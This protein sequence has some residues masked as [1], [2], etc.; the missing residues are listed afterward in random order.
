[1]P[2]ILKKFSMTA[3]GTEA[4][5]KSY[6]YNDANQLLKEIKTASGTTSTTTYTYDNNGNQLAKSTGSTATSVTNTYNAFNQLTASSVGGTST[7]YTYTPDGLRLTKGNLT[8]LYDRGN[9]VLEMQNSSVKSSYVYGIGLVSGAISGYSGQ[10]YFIHNGHGDI[11]QLQNSSRTVV[12]EYTYDAFGN[13]ENPVSADANPFRYAGEYYDT[14]TG[15]Y[16]LR[17]RYYDPVVGRFTQEDTVRAIS[18][19]LP[20]GQSVL[21]P[22][23]QNLYVYCA[24][25]PV[26]Y[27]DGSGHAWETLF[28]W[29]SFLDSAKKAYEEPSAENFLFAAWDAG[30]VLLPLVPASYSVKVVGKIDDIV[31]A[32]KTVDKVTDSVKAAGKVDN[33]GKNSKNLFA[34]SAPAKGFHEMY[35]ESTSFNHTFG[36]SHIKNGILNLGDGSRTPEN[37][38]AIWKIINSEVELNRNSFQRGSN[39]ILTT[40]NGIDTTVKVNVQNGLVTSIDAFVGASSRKS[41][42]PI[43]ISANRVG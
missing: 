43:I 37:K 30:S 7:A 21:E 35:N 25:N 41:S 42:N 40:I 12:K 3:S 36:E 28:D 20:N 8:Y 32:G 18:R 13:E 38:H 24:N 22:L 10:T 33:I 1:M 16:Y 27:R 2:A 29:L 39:T 19:T 6:T 11:V 15:T 23:S 17:A 31:D 34:K 14:N 4:Y 5:T 26:K 9:L